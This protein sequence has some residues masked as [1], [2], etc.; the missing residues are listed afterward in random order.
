MPDFYM[1][2]GVPGS[3]KSTWLRDNF[4]HPAVYCSTDSI[5]EM[6]AQRDGKTYNDVFKEHI[7]SATRQMEDTMRWAFSN[8]V[9][10]V[11]DQTNLTPKSRARKLSAVPKGYRK[12]AV[13]LSVP[14]REEWLRRLD[15]PGKTIPR[16]VL[17]NM[18]TTYQP[19]D[20]LEGFD[21][22]INVA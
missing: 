15:R 11:L 18:L 1:M 16:H 2:V 5:I 13:V 9:N 3:G 12:I 17:E 19:P 8:D 20:E 4:P 14:E 21:Q 6:R 7:D 10:V 22:V